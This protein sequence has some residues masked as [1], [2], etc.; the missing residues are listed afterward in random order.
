VQELPEYKEVKL[1]LELSGGKNNNREIT[2]GFVTFQLACKDIN[3]MALAR[4]AVDPIVRGICAVFF[5][6]RTVDVLHKSE[7]LKGLYNEN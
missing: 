3:M 4:D 5:P 2:T 6:M 7:A 1:E